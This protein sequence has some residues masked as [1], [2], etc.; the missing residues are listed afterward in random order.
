MR[1]LNMVAYATLPGVFAGKYISGGRRGLCAGGARGQT[2]Q[3]VLFRAGGGG[4]WHELHVRF[5]GASGE[6]AGGVHVFK[7]R[8]T[9]RGDVS[10]GRSAEG[11]RVRGTLHESKLQLLA[12]VSRH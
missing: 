4:S 8:I 12:F 11:W 7:V 5:T 3:A 9:A 1:L 6:A 10:S 2:F